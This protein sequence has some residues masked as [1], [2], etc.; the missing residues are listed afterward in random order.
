MMSKLVSSHGGEGN[1]ADYCYIVW[2]LIG[3]W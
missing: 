3:V 1:W 2:G